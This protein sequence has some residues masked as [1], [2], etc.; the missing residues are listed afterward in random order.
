MEKPKSEPGAERRL[1]ADQPEKEK[2]SDGKSSLSEQFSAGERAIY[3][4]DLIQ[5]DSFW[6]AVANG[7]Y[8]IN[9]DRLDKRMPDYLEIRNS[10]DE[11][12]LYV[13][14]L[15]EKDLELKFKEQH[16]SEAN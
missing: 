5:R 9:I 11:L 10:K 15:A 6:E 4:F 2:L 3:F 12:L 13:N 16:L 1:P 7:E 8:K 14:F